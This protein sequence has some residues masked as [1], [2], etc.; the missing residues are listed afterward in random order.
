MIVSI[1][2]VLVLDRLLIL[3][4]KLQAFAAI[5]PKP[6][7]DLL[8][9][10]TPGRVDLSVWDRRVACCSHL[11]LGLDTDLVAVLLV[12]DEFHWSVLQLFELFFD[13]FG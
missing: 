10:V 5:F 3:A 4:N 2:K 7:E 9:G 1:F 13:L 11:V 12:G 6:C 8:L